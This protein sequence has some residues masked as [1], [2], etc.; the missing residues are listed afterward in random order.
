MPDAG[1]RKAVNLG[2]IIQ[3]RITDNM[4]LSTETL[5]TAALGLQAPWQVRKVELSTAK[6]RIDFEVE[7]KVKRVVCQLRQCRPSLH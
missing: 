5:F 3:L 7:C 1:V 2:V 6:N 4:G